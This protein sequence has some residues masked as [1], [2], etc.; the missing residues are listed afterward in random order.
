MKEKLGT[1]TC[2]QV[3]RTIKLNYDFKVKLLVLKHQALYAKESILV[4]KWR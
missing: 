2:V 3:W 1:L 4:L